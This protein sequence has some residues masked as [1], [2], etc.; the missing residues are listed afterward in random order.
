MGKIRGAHYLLCLALFFGLFGGLLGDR[1]VLAAYQDNDATVLLPS[2]PEEPPPAEPPE[3]ALE[4]FS[5]YPILQ[6]TMGSFFEFE[7]TLYYEGSEPRT[8][9]LDM[10]LPEG[11]TGVFTGGY[12][13]TEVSAFTVEPGKKNETI[14][15]TVSPA[16]ENLPQP[17]EYVFTVRAAAENLTASVDLKAIV[18][19]IPHQYILYMS[20][21]TLQSEFSVRPDQTNHIT[22]QLTNAFSGTVNNIIFTAEEPAGWDITFTPGT[23]AVL[24]PG[25]T[26]EIDVVITP[27]TGTEAG[28]YPLTLKAIGD[29][30]ETEREYRITVVTSTAW[31]SAGIGIAVAIIVGL[32][33]WFRQS[34][35]RGEAKTKGAETAAGSASWFRRA[36]SR[37]RR[38]GER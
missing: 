7:I 32:A 22:I 27:P 38:A 16:S 28:D 36:A 17:G 25:V 5:S 14:T 3:E 30:T 20:T 35:R 4:V 33:I 21:A 23:V 29:Q 31:G 19:P 6:N 10:V 18:F 12:P 9:D 11:W 15:L 24:E 8:F 2:E 34:G 26:Q 1:M 13:E 37:F